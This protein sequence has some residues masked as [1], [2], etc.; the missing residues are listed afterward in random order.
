MR[1]SDG[2]KPLEAVEA[3]RIDEPTGDLE[4]RAASANGDHSNVRVEEAGN[5]RRR[6]GLVRGFPSAG[7]PVRIGPV[8]YRICACVAFSA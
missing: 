7:G 5:A 3:S 1:L 8:A 4:R 6:V 2:A